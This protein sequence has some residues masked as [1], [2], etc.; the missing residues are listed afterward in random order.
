MR[1]LPAPATGPGYPRATQAVL[2]IQGTGREAASHFGAQAEPWRAP[3][4]RPSTGRSAAGCIQSRAKSAGVW[5]VR[6][7]DERRLAA[8]YLVIF[9]LSCWLPARVLDRLHDLVVAG[10]PAK[11]ARQRLFDGV[12]IRL[13]VSPPAAWR[14]TSQSPGYSNRTARLHPARRPAAPGGTG[15]PGAN[16]SMVVILALWALGAGTRHDITASPSRNTVQAPHSPSAQP[17][18]DPVSPASSRRRRRRD[19]ACP[20]KA[21]RVFR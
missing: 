4:P 17:S 8:E 12:A 10:A 13:T 19:L 20:G 1:S 3:A 11:I 7:V 9:H 15:L 14:W 18:F 16:P 21:G 5:S 2:R 6:F